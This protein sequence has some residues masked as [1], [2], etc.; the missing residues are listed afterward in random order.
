MERM[1]IAFDIQEAQRQRALLHYGG[2]EIVDVFDTLPDT[3]ND[4]AIVK[5]KVMNILLPNKASTSNESR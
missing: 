3:G 2:E 4:F 5:L 1:F